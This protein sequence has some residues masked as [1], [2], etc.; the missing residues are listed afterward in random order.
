MPPRLLRLPKCLIRLLEVWNSVLFLMKMGPSPIRPSCPP[1]V[2]SSVNSGVP[3]SPDPPRARCFQ[4][5]IVSS[6][7]VLPGWPSAYS[8]FSVTTVSV[9][10]LSAIDEARWLFCAWGSSGD[11]GC[12]SAVSAARTLSCYCPLMEPFGSFICSYFVITASELL[13]FWLRFPVLLFDWAPAAAG[14]CCSAES[15]FIRPLQIS[16]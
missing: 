13:A 4:P 1:T 6:W 14:Y 8:L 16:S 2:A 3:A 11:A 15:A 12:S 10:W 7:S 9:S 5:S